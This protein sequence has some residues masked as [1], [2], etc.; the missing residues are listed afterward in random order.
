M[1]NNIT[2]KNINDSQKL[3]DFLK[4]II[5]DDGSVTFNF[6]NQLSI[7]EFIN[8]FKD[9]KL[10][11]RYARLTVIELNRQNKS[12]ILDF[13]SLY[14]KIKKKELSASKE[15]SLYTFYIPFLAAV[16]KTTNLPFTINILGYKF[17]FTSKI[18][19]KINY[20]RKLPHFLH[21]HFEEIDKFIR[22]SNSVF[23]KVNSVGFNERN[24]WSKIALPFD[25]LRGI[26]ELTINFGSTS[27]FSGQKQRAKIHHPNWLLI[28]S[29]NKP[30]NGMTFINDYEHKPF[31]YK[32]DQNTYE[33][34]SNNSLAFSKKISSNNSSTELMVTALRQYADALS[35]KFNYNQLLGLWQVAE[36]LTLSKE[37][38][39]KTSEVASRLTWFTK[40]ERFIASGYKN[41]LLAIAERRN[42]IVHRGISEISDDDVDFLKFAVEMTLLWFFQNIKQLK[43]INHVSEFY[44]LR[45]KNNSDIKTIKEILKFVTN[46]LRSK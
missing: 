41:T 4:T 9:T 38:N 25:V 44:R 29:K 27:F 28:F 39:G 43:T 21:P 20:Q 22:N 11:D 2:P 17:I 16:D 12:N 26:I 13:C 18:I 40:R 3:L 32:F 45:D 31:L 10:V 6:Y 23:I 37:F 36:T 24:A 19:N 8:S 14:P 15:E 5:K 7:Y 1:P 35:S 33:A 34:V 46:N 30:L 42:D